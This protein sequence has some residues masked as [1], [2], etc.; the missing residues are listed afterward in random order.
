VTLRA[1]LFD[2]DFTLSQPG[3]ALG[4]EG[5]VALGLRHGLALDAAR[6]DEARAAALE[7]FRYPAD[8]RHDDSLWV[9]FTEDIIRGLGGSSPAVAACARD[10]VQAWETH[11]NF[12]LYADA[13]PVLEELRHVGLRIGLISNT[14]RDLPAF[15]R[16]HRLDVDIAI[17]S[18]AHG[19]TKPHP[20]IFQAALEGL[21]IAPHEAVMVG[22]SVH[23]DIGGAAQLGIPAV[24][25]DRDDRH[26]GVT[27]RL[28]D[29]YGLTAL[30]GLARQA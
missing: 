26:P 5:Y 18:R 10:M 19:R 11:D 25:L 16:H 27:P 7:R 3:P 28:G 12:A 30:L 22:D 15:V 8:H 20:S 14:G 4:P 21:D 24:L 29:L 1:V 2:V 9:D 17:A 6:H 23:D 13:L